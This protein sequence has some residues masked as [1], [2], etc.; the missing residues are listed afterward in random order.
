MDTTPAEYKNDPVKRI[1][2]TENALDKSLRGL[3]AAIDDY[4]MV[5]GCRRD[6]DCG[7]YIN[8]GLILLDYVPIKARFYLEQIINNTGIS[9]EQRDGRSNEEAPKGAYFYLPIEKL[10][11]GKIDELSAAVRQAMRELGDGPGTEALARGNT[12]TGRPR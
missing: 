8:G 3:G 7:P 6:I 11:L 9:L 2:D 12:R 10:T 1:L 4:Y 5:Y